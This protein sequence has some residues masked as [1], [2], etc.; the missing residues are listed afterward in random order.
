M[1][2]FGFLREAITRTSEHHAAL[3]SGDR[4]HAL[5]DIELALQA[6]GVQPE[7]ARL[8]LGH[9]VG[10]GEEAM[11]DT[12]DGRAVIYCDALEALNRKRSDPA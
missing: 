9:V 7:E 4:P 10:W 12:A 3:A 5:A 8:A 2:L 6:H 1:G 11:L